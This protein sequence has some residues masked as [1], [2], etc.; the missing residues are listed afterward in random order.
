MGKIVIVFGVGD[1]FAYVNAH[2][3]GVQYKI[4]TA[5]E[6]LLGFYKKVGNVIGAGNIGGDNRGVN[7]FG[8]FVDGT[9]A[10]RDRGIG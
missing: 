9:H 8:Q 7:F 5:A 6:V 2:T 4:H 1:V 10:Q 3:Y